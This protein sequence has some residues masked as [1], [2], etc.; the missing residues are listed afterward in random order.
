MQV[1][2]TG[3]ALIQDFEG[4]RAAPAQM[5]D[6][7]WLVG[8]G[9][10]RIGEAGETVTESEA[11][12]LLALDL[13]PVERVVKALAKVELTQSQFDALVSFAFS[14][15]LDAFAESAVLRRTNAG[16]D[17]Q[18]ACAMDAWRKSDVSGEL[19]TIDAL[20]RRRAAEKA[21]FLKD[22]AK[23]AAPSA[24][25]RAKLDHAAAILGAPVAYA[26]APEVGS[27]PVKPV[28]VDD[29]EIITEVL[30]SEPATETLLLTQ[31]VVDEEPAELEPVIVT[32]HAMPVARKL[33]GTAVPQRQRARR[34]P[35]VFAHPVESFGLIALLVFGLGLFALGCGQ[36]I[37]HAA[38]FI[39]VLSAV[40]LG[41]P[42]VAAVLIAG[43]GL[44]R[45]AHK[46]AVVA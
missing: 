23:Q 28:K 45:P 29:A 40:A 10:V 20:V 26:A 11:A 30:K 35:Q 42:G 31:V 25:M 34:K 44:T 27:I 4:F 39:S 14:I 46:L 15:G 7:N 17:V 5:P 13:A 24:F 1:S 38:D 6:G 21:L 41:G 2:E 16:D 18:A 43:F 3:L 12:H 19:E 22:T 9:H 37:G 33:D 8:Y 32:A 36:L